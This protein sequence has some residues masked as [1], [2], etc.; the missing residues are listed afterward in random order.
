THQSTNASPNACALSATGNGT[1]AG[2][3]N[4]CRG[5]G[6]DV[7]SFAAFSCHFSFGIRSLL[8][9][10]IGAPRSRKQVHCVPIRQDERFQPHTGS[11]APFDAS[12]APALEQ[13]A[14]Q[15]GTHWHHDLIVLS[16]RKGG[17]KIEGIARFAAARVNSVFQYNRKPPSLWNQ[18][19][20]ALRP[21]A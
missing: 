3:C 5:N 11:A 13:P 9:A 18:Q 6:S 1:N 21:F 10:C 4:S 19:F 15:I 2:T 7:L 8:A 20:S 16:G 12:R 17:M 14:S